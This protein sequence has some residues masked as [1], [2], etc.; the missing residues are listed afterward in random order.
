MREKELRL[1]LVCYGGI[2]LAVYMH[3]ITKEVWHLARASRAFY[4]GTPPQDPVEAAYVDLLEV[5]ESATGTK[6]RVLADIVA[7][8]SAGGINGIF[9]A[10]AVASGQSLDPLTDM[11][12]DQ[13]DVDALLDPEARAPSR[14]SKLWAS[15]IA[16]AFA[17]RQGDKWD[18]GLDSKTRDE[19]YAKL[20]RFVRSRWFEPP[21][22]GEVF[23][24]MLLGAFAAMAAGPQGARLLPDEQP[25]DLFVT[26]TDFS[27]HPEALPIHSPPMIVE[28]EHRLTLS[29]R[30]EPGRMAQLGEIP[31]LVFAA[32]AT[33]SFP[34]AFPP[35]TVAELDRVLDEAGQ[36]WPG[37]DAFIA[38]MLP[39]QVAAGT[40]ETTALIDGSVLAN[41]PFR[42]AIDALRDRPARREVDR[43]F[44]Y[45]DPKPGQKS[46]KLSGNDDTPGFFTTLFGAL[47]DIPRSQPIRDNLEAIAGR[48]AR[49]ARTRRIIEA[50]RPQ[51]EASVEHMFGRTLFLDRPTSARLA[52]WR[53][54]AGDRAARDAGHSAVAYREI[55]RAGIADALERATPQRIG[56]AALLHELAQRADTMPLDLRYRIR[57]LRFV[58]RRL[59]A[60]ADESPTVDYEG[61]RKT[62]FACLA[63]Y[64]ERESPHFLGSI[65]AAD[66][67]TLLDLIAARWD[68]ATLDAATDAAMAEAIGACFRPHRR[69]PL[70]AYLG[71]PFY[72]VATLALLQ[73][74]GFDEFDPVMV[75]RIAPEDAVSLSGGEAVL[76][77]IQF[78]SFG[79][80]FS[81]AYRENDYLWG[82]LH[83]A[84]RLIDIIVATLP[85]DAL[86]AEVVGRTKCA[87]FK[88]ILDREA[89]RLTAIPETFAELRHRLA[90][91]SG[92]AAATGLD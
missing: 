30:D 86:A 60:L 24:K 64:I 92:K 19:I 4:D 25:L 59:A 66:A 27:G 21:F 88:A 50:L 36:N 48:T 83:G 45:I 68:L 71:F 84:E 52:T 40:A 65:E 46:I 81:R 53:A 55:V 76:K 56:T 6:L 3:G 75:D 72:D 14:V 28:T 61:V 20:T 67:R 22:G 47:S 16:W 38:R 10:Q 1:A 31:G 33:A 63:R 69:Q 37:R 15:P 85:P 79:A 7:G 51:V 29:F 35:F 44:V 34:G 42:P 8:A 32:R 74:E 12:L 13:A 89:P 11:W 2:S 78:N 70:L 62:V 54:R 80:F 17:G 77:G 82:R 91:L 57:R 41:A 87:A 9:L 49:I 39:R 18:D 43:R 5:I 90:G 26:V 23:D 58:A 73:G